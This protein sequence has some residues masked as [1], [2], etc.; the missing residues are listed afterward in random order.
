MCLLAVPTADIYNNKEVV[1]GLLVM[2]MPY[3]WISRKAGFT[4]V[5]MEF[6]IMMFAVMESLY[7]HQG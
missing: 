5:Y 2:P 4:Q 6:H 1:M 3:A 7:P